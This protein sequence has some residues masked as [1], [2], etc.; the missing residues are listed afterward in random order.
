MTTYDFNAIE[1]KWQKYWEEKSLFN[2]KI[3]KS[4]KKFYALCEFPYPSGAGLHVGHPRGYTALDIVARRKRMQGFNVLYPMGFDSFGLPTEHYAIKTGIRPEV[5]TEQNIATFKA[6]MKSLGF[7]FAWEREVITSSPEYY[8]WTQWQFIQLFKLGLAYKETTEVW[9]CPKCKIGIANEELEAGR[10]ERCDAEV[11]K[12]TRE[13]WSLKMQSYSDRLIEGLSRV[14]FLENIKKMQIDWIGRSEGAEVE[15]P[16]SKGGSLRVFTT[17]PD[18]IAG[19]EFM[20]IS[21]EE[22]L[23][24][25]GPLCGGFDN[26]DEVCGY[27][28]AAVVR[29]DVERSQTKVKTGVPLAGLVAT[30]PYNGREIP[31]YTADY[32][33]YGYGTGAIM[34]V[35]D[36]DERDGEFANAMGI[37]FGETKLLS[38]DDALKVGE[39]KV[40]YKMQDW[41]FSRQ[42]YWGEPIPMVHC[43][44][45][46]WV[47]LPESELPLKLPHVDN[48]LP[49]D[50][51]S[52]PLARVAD[53]VNTKCPTCGG[54]AKRETDTMPMWAGSCWYYLRYM[55]AH[56]DRE[57]ASREAMDYWG[58]VDLYNGG[59]EHTT[60]HLLYA[61]FWSKALCDGGFIPNDEP[62][63]RRIMHGMILAEGGVKMSKSKNNVINP[64]DIVAEYGADTLR[65][66]EM[67]IGPYDQAVAWS[68]ESMIGV[69]RFL[70]R[71]AA[72]SERVE[73]R[74]ATVAERSVLAVAAR[75]V[76]E[77][78]DALKFN[79][80]V[81]ALMIALNAFEEGDSVAKSVF[82]DFVKLLSPFAP[83]LAEELWERLGNAESI[84]F[85]SWVEFDAADISAEGIVYVVQVGGK[86]RAEISV[87]A[88]MDQAEVE[89]LAM[90]EESVAKFITSP[91]KKVIFV[92]GKIVNIVI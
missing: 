66:Y 64:N 78:I 80:A 85:A 18:T 59:Q 33:L 44:M 29:T 24:R 1:K 20:V 69:H 54:A 32:V 65:V 63:M 31:V 75:D 21:P 9:W 34:A 60:R 76:S 6:Q 90:V 86:R 84:A 11:E 37:K 40:N 7:S 14:D 87:G 5:A 28:N 38:P 70:K 36:L 67:F 25:F 30:N 61:R 88:D 57:F 41:Q 8:R 72:L 46:G 26:S 23:E 12:K 10:C 45:C 91:V 58:Q 55:D 47:P 83:H 50:D 82:A 56:N 77:R 16:L 68:T 13:I 35:P 48:Y 73:D 4:K 42:R 52:S 2:P 81:S 79:T 71:A 17:R 51:G 22:V 89:R 92:P 27:V 15:F 3:D 74:A 43:S 62:F 49:T 19:V 39:R 53:W